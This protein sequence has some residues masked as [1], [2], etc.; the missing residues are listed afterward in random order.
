MRG[1]YVLQ[2]V[3][4]K[5]CKMQEMWPKYHIVMNSIV[6]ELCNHLCKFVSLKKFM[7]GKVHI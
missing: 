7:Y 5:Q 6:K 3:Q 2:I 4:R 1:S